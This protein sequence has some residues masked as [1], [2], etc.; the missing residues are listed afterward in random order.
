MFRR[1]FTPVKWSINDQTAD[2][3]LGEKSHYMVLETE[4]NKYDVL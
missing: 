1:F 2:G 3:F 4:K